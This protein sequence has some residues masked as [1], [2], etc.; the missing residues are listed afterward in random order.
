MLAILAP[1]EEEGFVAATWREGEWYPT[2]HPVV[3][4]WRALAG[5]SDTSMNAYT[6]LPED[7]IGATPDP[8]LTKL[9]QTADQIEV[10]TLNQIR[11]YFML[12][13]RG[14]RFCDGYIAKEFAEGRMLAALH[15]LRRLRQ[16]MP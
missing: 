8:S 12:C 14:E 6:V 11:R 16:E 9:T 5:K 10:A 4:A 7:P 15:R 2:Y 13:V 3:A 1:I